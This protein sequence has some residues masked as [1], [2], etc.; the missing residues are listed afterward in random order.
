MQLRELKTALERMNARLPRM[1]SSVSISPL[2]ELAVPQDLMPLLGQAACAAQV[3]VELESDDAPEN[4]TLKRISRVPCSEP[5]RCWLAA[6]GTMMGFEAVFVRQLPSHLLD[7]TTMS[8]LRH[9]TQVVSMGFA[10][11]RAIFAEGADLV[12]TFDRVLG[13]SLDQVGRL[14]PA[15]SLALL[16]LANNGLRALHA[17]GMTHGAIREKR[18][19]INVSGWPVLCGGFDSKVVSR[20]QDR[21]RLAR[22][23]LGTGFEDQLLLEIL[24]GG[25]PGA[26]EIAADRIVE[27]HPALS[28]LAPAALWAETSEDELAS[29]IVKTVP[30]EDA[31]FI[32]AAA[33]RE[34]GL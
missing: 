18:V 19:R 2:A 10:R 4:G 6:Q 11:P 14:T 5:E 16:A 31:F 29:M 26:C 8:I 15:S 30:R 1:R 17:S 24:D 27:T 25:A 12:A 21:A 9:W 20:E 3:F 23:I 28:E 7:R 22:V 13:A 32:V 34:C 33:V